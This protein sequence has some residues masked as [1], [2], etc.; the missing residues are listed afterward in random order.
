MN[1]IRQAYAEHLGEYSWDFYSTVTFRTTH[2][3]PLN[4]ASRVSR[5]LERLDC[6]RA[7]LAVERHRLDGVHVHTLHR[8][9]FRQDLASASVW[10]YFSKA[11]GRTT[12]ESPRETTAVEAYCAKYVTKDYG[13]GGESFHYFGDT[14]AWTLDRMWYNEDRGHMGNDS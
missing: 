7:F 14:A 9:T 10:K 5:A 8:H 3:D 2:R 11:F 12:V 6:T 4:A 13:L 1:D